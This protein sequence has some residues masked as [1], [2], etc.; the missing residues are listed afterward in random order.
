MQLQLQGLLFN[1]NA[2]GLGEGATFDQFDFF[3]VVPEVDAAAIH[4]VI[5]NHPGVI[6]GLI[7]LQHDV[8]PHRDRKTV[9][10]DQATAFGAD[11]G[12]LVAFLN[13]DHV[14]QVN[15]G[16]G[17]G[18]GVV[19]KGRTVG[20]P[21]FR[22]DPDAGRLKTPAADEPLD[23]FLI[24]IGI[25][26]LAGFHRAEVILFLGAAD[27]LGP[28]APL[29]LQAA[30]VVEVA[31]A[32]IDGGFDRLV[33]FCFQ[34]CCRDRRWAWRDRSLA[35]RRGLRRLGFRDSV[36]LIGQG[37]EALVLIRARCARAAGCGR[38]QWRD[39]RRFGLAIA[40]AN[41]DQVGIA[42]LA[43]AAVGAIGTG[44]VVQTTDHGPLRFHQGFD[45]KAQIVE[46][47]LVVLPEGL[48][49][50]AVARQQA[51]AFKEAQA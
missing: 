9:F 25:P 44:A 14:F 51:H 22:C 30:D 29:E 13:G 19:A 11:L 18:E 16:L 4:A 10:K 21:S 36:Q 3:E 26:Q 31:D 43:D 49:V 37:L 47:G 46:E 6:G 28:C 50:E 1:A 45:L 12:A 34:F 24:A 5:G 40:V 23:Q 32:L 39:P 15:P 38:H 7:L 2:V 41:A 17:R 20:R 35:G 48:L 27:E 8:L 42:A 33:A